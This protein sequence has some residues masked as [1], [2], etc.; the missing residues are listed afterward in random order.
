MTTSN[1]NGNRNGNRHGATDEKVNIST[2]PISPKSK[3]VYVSG[4]IHPDIKVPFREISLSASTTVN[5]NG[6]GYHSEE[7]ESSLIVYDTSGP[8]TD[9]DTKI[10]IREGL[11]PI[12]L[13][14]I[15]GRGDVEY[16]DGRK[17]EPK[18]DGYREGENPN[19]ERFPKTR[20]KVLR[21]KSGQNVSQMYY[22][23]RGIITPEME[24][25]AIRENQ[26]RKQ[27]MENEE[28][29]QRLTGNSFGASL[30]QEITPEFVRDEVARGRA[31]I[32]AN[33]N[34]PESEPMIIGRNFLVKITANIGNS[35][36]TSSIEDEFE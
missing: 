9:P 36:V 15:I 33:I 19:T 23:K 24:F 6:N 14:W 27:W 29:E 8:Y 3:K 21:A 28:R 17:I 30:P 34:H 25:I 22:A 12:R 11:D 31:I 32:P 1:G 20:D 4:T 5:G 16:Y 13:P 18:D 35:A 7:D 26:K 2:D 10:D